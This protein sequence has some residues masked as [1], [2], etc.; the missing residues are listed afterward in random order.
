[1][2]LSDGLFIVWILISICI[3]ALSIFTFSIAQQNKR[4][5]DKIKTQLASGT[6]ANIKTTADINR[7]MKQKQN[8]L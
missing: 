5:I 4:D 6:G 2:N 3:F 1:M 7:I 8:K